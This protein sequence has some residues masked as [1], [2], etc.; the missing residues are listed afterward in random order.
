MS[1]LSPSWLVASTQSTDSYAG[2]FF[3]CQLLGHNF[4]VFETVLDV[5][6]I[7]NFHKSFRWGSFSPF[8]LFCQILSAWFTFFRWVEL[9]QIWRHFLF[10]TTLKNL[11]VNCSQVF[12][13]RQIAR[14]TWKL[15]WPLCFNMWA[16]IL[17]VI[18]VVRVIAH[19][20]VRCCIVKL[21]RGE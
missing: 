19:W 4:F 1:P 17:I 16:F 2:Y 5:E 21:I 13:L 12:K 3:L 9:L 6:L 7:G 10:L 11:L 15:R 18:G 20:V 8:S 14:A